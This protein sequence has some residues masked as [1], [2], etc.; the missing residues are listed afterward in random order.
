MFDILKKKASIFK[1]SLILAIILAISVANSLADT[2]D[3]EETSVSLLWTAHW[4]RHVIHV[5]KTT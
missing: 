5:K 3:N 4:L 2:N 1:I